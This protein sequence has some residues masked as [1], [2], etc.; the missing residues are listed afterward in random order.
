MS[1]RALLEPRQDAENRYKVRRALRLGSVLGG[2]GD[3]VIIHNL[4][5]TGFLVETSADLT[6][7]ETLEVDLPEGG[8]V[9]ASVVWR[10]DRFYG[11]E[12]ATS[13]PAAVVSAAALRSDVISPAADFST[14]TAGAEAPP[15]KFEDD[16]YPLPVRMLVIL[17]LS[18]AAWVLV[19]LVIIFL[20]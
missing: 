16:R 13:V 9:P 6:S 1:V 15:S 19:G 3:E 12:F 4:S 8:L 7:G 5:A 10:R 17:G 20:V 18:I 11:C 14:K 2:S